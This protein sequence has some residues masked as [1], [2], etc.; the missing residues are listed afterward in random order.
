MK[1]CQQMNTLQC[2]LLRMKCQFQ[3]D[4][5][6][7]LKCTKKHEHGKAPPTR[8]I[9]SCSGTLTEHIALFVE[10]NIKDVAQTHES[11]L[12][13]YIQSTPN[14]IHNVTHHS[15]GRTG[16]ASLLLL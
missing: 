15:E 5:I 7:P 3:G 11:Y 14:Q 2:Y 9:V 4:F 12:Q 8:G 1:Y 16:A 13:K 6:A 10:N